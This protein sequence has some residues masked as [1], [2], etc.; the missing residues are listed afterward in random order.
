M[1][2]LDIKD[3]LFKGE[4]IPFYPL[5]ASLKNGAALRM[6]EHSIKHWCWSFLKGFFVCLCV[7]THVPGSQGWLPG[8]LGCFSEL[9]WCACLCVPVPAFLRGLPTMYMPRSA[10]LCFWDRMR[11]GLSQLF[12]SEHTYDGLESHWKVQENEQGHMSYCPTGIGTWLGQ[13][14]QFLSLNQANMKLF[15]IEIRLY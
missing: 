6:G 15:Y 1:K 3:H 12:R 7:N 2:K 11:L 10:L 5:L 14:H 4:H 8:G 9:A 13:P